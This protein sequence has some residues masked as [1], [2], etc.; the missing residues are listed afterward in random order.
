MLPALA[1]LAV[2]ATLA[3]APAAQAATAPTSTAATTTTASTTTTVPFTAP[4]AAPKARLSDNEAIFLF[5]QDP[6]VIHWLSRYPPNPVKQATFS[7]GTWTVDVWSGAA[8]EIA[9][10]TVDDATGTITAAWTGPQVAWS[11]ARGIPGAFGGKKINS[12]AVWLGFCAVFLVGLID[13]RRLFSL[14]NLDLL[15]L[16][17]FFTVSLW[18]FNRGHV[19]AAMIVAY[20]GLFYLLGR[21]I[22]IGTRDRPTYGAPVWP[23]WLLIGATVFLIGF[24]IGLNVR[25]SNVIDVGLSGVIGAERIWAGQSPYGN[26][27]IEGNLP[28]CGPA[29]ASGEIRDHIQ[30]DHRCEA[31][32]PQGDTYGP[33]AYEAY[34]PGYWV[35]GWSGLW[36]SLPAVHATSILWDLL[37]IFGLGLVGRR[38]GGPR[39]G[40]TL[41]F[42]WA[43]WP[44]TQYASNSNSNDMIM[45]ALLAWGFFFLTSPALRGA[46]VALS[47]WT[48]FAPLLLLPL[49]A[50]YPEA[51]F[52]RS[53][54]RYAIGFVVATAAAFFVLFLEP[55]PIHAAHEFVERTFSY[56][57]G[58]ASPF[59][60][61]DWRQYHARGL[62][63]LHGVQI[64]LQVWLV[65]GALVLGRFPRR[66]SPLRIAAFSAALL[67]GF[68]LVLTHWFYLYLPWFFPF[69][70]YALLAPRAAEEPAVVPEAQPVPQALAPA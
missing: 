53:L 60:L 8:G 67:I 56:Q 18:E 69:V 33:V 29:D 35:F 51:R 39:L 48:K 9:T 25:D 41:A 61:W 58:R 43:A 47:A 32:D 62:P 34:L 7:K 50:G 19:F 5:M 23:T 31:A 68:E 13:W 20:P 65:V 10:G 38:F 52:D 24:R 27:P 4:A 49:W 45:P 2:L 6:K 57:L 22:W 26:F 44:F 54:R 37:A 17:S 59:S 21:C 3:G 46:F 70:A 1:V 30:A 11:M 42:A 12:Y 16:V 64:V 36:D 28:A 14:R 15:A 55:N 63:N 66:R 40:A